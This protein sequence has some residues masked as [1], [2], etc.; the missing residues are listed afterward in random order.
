MLGLNIVCVQNLTT[1]AL[2]V[3]KIMVGANLAPTIIFGTAKA[4]VVNCQPKFMWFT[5]PDCDC[6]PSMG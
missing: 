4:R 3:P 6:L 5:R 2:A 1:L